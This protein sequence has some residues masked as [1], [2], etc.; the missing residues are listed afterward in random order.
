[1]TLNEFVSTYNGK[2]ID[3]DGSYGAQCT[4]LMR[5]YCVDVLSIPGY[6]IIPALYARQMFE[7]FPLLGDQHFTKILNTKNNV[8]NKGD[9]IFWGYKW[10][11]TGYAGHVAIF[12]DG[13][14]NRFISFDQ[15]YP[16]H[17]PCRYHNHAY[18]GVLGWLRHRKTVK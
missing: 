3:Y 10:P 13:N 11:T 6:S 18:R 15:N 12:C 4:D 1:M 2:Y 9:I 7:R 5:Q 17:T 14:V 8:P 16:N